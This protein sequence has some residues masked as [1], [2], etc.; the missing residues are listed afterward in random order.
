MIWTPLNVVG[1]TR[2]QVELTAFAI[3]NGW[4][5]V[6]EL[7]ASFALNN[8]YYY[9]IDLTTIAPSASCIVAVRW[10]NADYVT[11]RVK[12]W[13]GIGEI[14]YFPVYNGQTI[15]PFSVFEIWNVYGQSVASLS[16][17]TLGIS[18][19]AQETRCPVCDVSR[20]ITVIGY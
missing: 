17:M 19:L 15:G 8:S 6:S 20:N 5:G 7:L 10:T 13:D 18:V 4:N 12:L 3:A 9:N 2:W 16:A 1:P 14:L 11:F